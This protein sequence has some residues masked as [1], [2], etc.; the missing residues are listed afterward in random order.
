MREDTQG[1][2]YDD[3]VALLERAGKRLAEAEQS[4]LVGDQATIRPGFGIY[5]GATVEVISVCQR[6]EGEPQ[7]YAVEWD[8]GHQE[9]LYEEVLRPKPDLRVVGGSND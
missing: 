3:T 4:F 2:G 6:S 1:T 5:P 8:N 7:K 9:V